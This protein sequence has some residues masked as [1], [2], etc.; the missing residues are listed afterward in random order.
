MS[1]TAT[2][3]ITGAVM[4]ASRELVL[5]P[6]VLAPPGATR[7]WSGWFRPGSARPTWKPLQ[8]TSICCPCRWCSTR[9]SRR[10][11]A[12]QRRRDRVGGRGHRA[13]DV[14]RC[15]HARTL[16]AGTR[17]SDTRTSYKGLCRHMC[18][19]LP[20]LIADLE[21]KLLVEQARP[22]WSG[23]REP[24]TDIA[25]RIDQ[26][27]E[28]GIGQ[29]LRCGSVLQLS[30][31]RSS[32]SLHFVDVFNRAMGSTSASIAVCSRRSRAS[33]FVSRAARSKVSA[34]WCE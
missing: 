28:L 8:A 14:H 32:F 19:L 4:R 2:R 16:A 29:Y 11:R 27:V 7:S 23:F 5:E 26:G 1:D 21:P 12:G 9:R 6:L 25:E 13:D 17:P 34:Q 10:G 20:R 3:R 30:S 18:G 33:A 15:A 24:R 22:G 31:C